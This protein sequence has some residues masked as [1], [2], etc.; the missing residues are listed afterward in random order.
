MKKN[1]SNISFTS[2][3]K[4]VS[5]SRYQKI[6][7]LPRTIIVEEM[8]KVEN[9]Q[10]VKNSGATKDIIFCIAGMVGVIKKF[11]KRS[12]F[13][14]H[15]QPKAIFKDTLEERASAKKIGKKMKSIPAQRDLKGFL[16]GGL[17]KDYSK[18]NWSAMRMINFLEQNI[19]HIKK[20]DFSVFL[21]QDSY[22]LASEE[23]PQCAFVYHKKNDT[24]YVNCRKMIN[25][26]WQDLLDKNQIYQH[27]GYIKIS[28]QDKVF[29]GN[30][31]V[32]NEF[33]NKSKEVKSQK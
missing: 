15:W 28:P 11:K 21:F 30:K 29:I 19:K 4:F 3:I 17:S 32:S 9:V 22:V 24:C 20:R 27:F 7:N 12:D 23:L 16:F 1:I 2:N 14:F 31:P 6:A 33:W 26:H 8:A 18:E 10:K 25:E 13:I 5:N